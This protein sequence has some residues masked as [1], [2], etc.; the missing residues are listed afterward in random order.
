MNISFLNKLY[1]GQV[2]FFVLLVLGIIPREVAT[3]FAVFLTGYFI[4]AKTEDSVIF[5]V[6]SIPLFVAIPIIDG[7]DN[8]NT[9]RILSLVVFIKWLFESGNLK[10]I[11]SLTIIKKIPLALNFRKTDFAWINYILIISALSM[12]L[13]PDK[14]LALKRMI[15]FINLSLVGIV[16]YYLVQRNIEFL[17]RIIKNITVPTIIVIIVGFMQLAL[18]YFIDI[19]QFMAFWGEGIQCRQFGQE[20][21]DIAVW[22][23]NTWFAYYGEQLSLRMFS[24]FP[25]SHSFPIFV[26]LGLPALLAIS[27]RKLTADPER[28]DSLKKMIKTRVSL[29]IVWVALG[30]LAGILSGTRGIWAASVGVLIIIVCVIWWNRKINTDTNHKNIFKYLASYMSVFFMLFIIAWPIF[31]SPQFLLSKGN[32]NLLSGRIKS[33]VD[34]GETSNSQRLAIWDAT[35]KSIYKKPLLGVGIGNY[36]VIL[37]QDLFLSRAGSS[38]HNL[39]LHITGEIGIIGG[40][41]TIWFLWLLFIRSWQ[42]FIKTKDPLNITYFAGTIIFL[43]WVL[44]YSLTDV[45]IFDERAFSLFIISAALI[46]SQK[47]T[48]HYAR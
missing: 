13:A 12:I 48:N 5:F 4:F 43:P 35:V 45:A 23:G 41:I 6:R 10:E 30:L 9:W 8:F 16:I 40:L 37:N 1:I 44:I 15:Y 36:P 39:Y 34:F 33:I 29:N 28:Y 27:I 18:T 24:L 25:D 3:V 7:F 14:M 31:V 46:F 19:Y 32:W 22:L 47:K 42:A 21:C 2:I 26:L 38:A 17:N 11:L 20:W